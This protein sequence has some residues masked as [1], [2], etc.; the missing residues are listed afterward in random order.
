MFTARELAELGRQLTEPDF[1][2]QMGP[3]ALMQRPPNE[4][5][6]ERARSQWEVSTRVQPALKL[7]GGA[8][9]SIDFG[10]LVIATLPPPA[11]DSS[12]QLLIGRSPDCDL[13]IQDTSV[14][15]HHAQVRWDGKAAVLEELGSSNGTFINNLKMKDRWTL[16][17]GDQVS[18]GESHFY[19]WWAATLHQRLKT[20]R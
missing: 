14:S 19:F 6:V 8:Q 13:V 2:R 16:R 17:D 1:E 11:A 20:L 10:D 3:F 15:K 12:M 18:F 5:R 4:A 9:S 7:R